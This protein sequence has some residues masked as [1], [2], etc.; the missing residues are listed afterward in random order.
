MTAQA[1]YLR[2]LIRAAVVKYAT[3]IP[4]TGVLLSG[5]IDSSTIAAFAPGLPAFTGWYE[6]EAYDERLYARLAVGKRE[7]HE[8]EITPEDF[9][10]FFDE[11][12]EAVEPPFAGPGTFG[13]FMVAR[14]VSKQGIQ[15]V[16]SGE[17]GDELFGGYARQH[18]VAGIEPPTGYEEYELPEDYPR[19]LEGALAYDWEHLPDLLRVDEQVTSFHGITAVAPMLEPEIVEWV[20]RQPPERRVG[21]PL[22]KEAMQGVIP[23]EILARRDK[24]GFTVPYVEWAQREP[25]RSFI[26]ERIGYVPDPAKP[27][28]RKWW[29]DLCQGQKA[30]V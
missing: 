16:L 17:G 26:A 6:G 20:L 23:D 22:L 8:I 7:H 15:R 11:M 21:K 14:Y 29:L 4:V 12:L 27:W 13:Q 10:E 19:D 2:A 25:V 5:G 18:I 30:L 3:R 9:V 28:D 1:T 24:M